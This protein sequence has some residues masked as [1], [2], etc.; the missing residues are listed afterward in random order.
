[1]NYNEST[2]HQKNILIISKKTTLITPLLHFFPAN[3][4]DI[5]PTLNKKDDL[6]EKYVLIFYEITKQMDENELAF[7]SDFFPQRMKAKLIIFSEDVPSFVH[8]S[9]KSLS[10]QALPLFDYLTLKET[11]ERDTKLF[12]LHHI[13][14]IMMAQ[15]ITKEIENKLISSS[16]EMIKTIKAFKQLTKNDLPLLIEGEF[17]TGKT[18]FIHYFLFYHVQSEHILYI[19][20]KIMDDK[21]IKQLLLTH[22]SKACVVFSDFD[23]QKESAQNSIIT[24]LFKQSLSCIFEVNTKENSHENPVLLD[25][26]NAK[27]GKQI[28][29]LPLRERKTD[30]ALITEQFLYSMSRQSAQYWLEITQNGLEKLQQHYWMGNITELLNTL[31]SALI[32]SNGKL[33]TSNKLK[34]TAVKTNVTNLNLKKNRDKKEKDIVLKALLLSEHNMSKTAKVLG[35]SRPTLYSLIAKYQL[36]HD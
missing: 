5:K 10:A 28:N 24:H 13:Y 12:Y 35:I 36:N 6:N 3:V 20:C 16:F 19:D 31:R 22:Q 26:I 14:Q 29:L 8:F 9:T 1:M 34:M 2:W 18:S 25:Y 7:L 15:Q 27:K 4:I 32:L 23:S 30:I 21:K 11:K 17:G 33:I